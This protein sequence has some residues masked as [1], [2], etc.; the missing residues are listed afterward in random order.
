MKQQQTNAKSEKKRMQWLQQQQQQQQQ[1][2]FFFVKIAA[3][4]AAAHRTYNRKRYA[5]IVMRDLVIKYDGKLHSKCSIRLAL[6][7]SIRFNDR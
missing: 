7:L 4:A 5:L 2:I 6:A 3:A 1:Y